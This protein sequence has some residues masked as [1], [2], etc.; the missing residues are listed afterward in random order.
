M[1]RGNV[2]FLFRY[3]FFQSTLGEALSFITIV[4]LSAFDF[5]YVKNVSGRLL[6]GL[7]WWNEVMDDGKEKWIFE[8]SNEIH[9]SNIDTTI[10]WWTLYITPLFWGVFL[11][12]NLISFSFMDGITCFLCM[13]L[14]ISNTLGYYR[15]SKDQSKKISS[16]F[17]E[18]STA[19]ITKLMT[20]GYAQKMMGGK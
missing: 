2:I 13:I 10:F 6:V 11:I 7:R 4:I 18:Q 16:F 14:S 20:S 17:V 1:F 12:F 8:S 15:C 9:S 5:W 3:L 19:G